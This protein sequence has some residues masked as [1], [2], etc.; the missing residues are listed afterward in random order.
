MQ[1]EKDVQPWDAH[2]S[3][4]S[5]VRNFCQCLAFPA[6]FCQMWWTP[7]VMVFALFFPDE[8]FTWGD[9]AMPGTLRIGNTSWL[10]CTFWLGV[11]RFQTDVLIFFYL[12][13]F[14]F[15]LVYSILKSLIKNAKRGLQNLAK[16]KSRVQV[17]PST[18]LISKFALNYPYL[19]HT[20]MCPSS[21]VKKQH[22]P[23]LNMVMDRPASGVIF[24]WIC[25]SFPK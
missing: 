3:G 4:E 15:N 8:I 17:F 6:C 25:I 23:S 5:S 16:K 2:L 14:I 1:G 19:K 22:I 12:L 11:F 18:I 20:T 7:D 10:P 24:L 9:T 21:L 13:L